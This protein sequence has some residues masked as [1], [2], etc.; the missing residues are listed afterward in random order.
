MTSYANSYTAPTNF[1]MIQ[2]ELIRSSSLS[3][4]AFKLLCIGLSH[5]GIW[6]FYKK[7]ISTCFKE[8]MHTLDEA[9][10]ELRALGY[11]HLVAKL[12]NGNKFE[13]H[14]W[15]WFS[16]PVNEEE[17]KKFYRDGDFHGLGD[18]GSSENTPDIR[19]P[20]IKKTN[21]NKKTDL[22]VANDPVGPT[23]SKIKVKKSNEEFITITKEDI[24]RLAASSRKNHDENWTIEE[25]EYAF[26]SLSKY[27]GIVHNW[28]RFIEGT[29]SN[30][31]N[32]KKSKKASGDRS[33]KGSKHKN[34]KMDMES[35]KT[36]ITKEYKNCKE[37]CSDRDTSA[38]VSGKAGSLLELILK[39]RNG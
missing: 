19:R 2:N 13:G 14:R 24:F 37:D 10:K 22:S 29:I 1:T 39:S 5:S 28:S 4:K 17:F 38:P 15:F 33:T 9:M 3:C 26:N 23:A 21:L 11:L 27:T 16:S 8:G 32:V 30:Y 20:I 6:A 12:G 7:Q 25:I 36:R 18:T 31:R 34:H 35:C